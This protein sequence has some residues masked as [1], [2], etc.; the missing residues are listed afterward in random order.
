MSKKRFQ[1]CGWLEKVWRYRFYIPIPFIYVWMAYIQPMVVTET[2]L[3]EES[4]YIEPTGG[5]YNPKGK[6]LWRILVGTAQG[7]MNWTITME[8]MKEHMDEY[9]KEFKKKKN[10]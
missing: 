9:I 5:Y 10:E 7:K 6:N 4:G 2:E 3:N 8:E 1:E